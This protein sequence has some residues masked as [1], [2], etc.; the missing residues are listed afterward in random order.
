MNI[1]KKLIAAISAAVSVSAFAATSAAVYANETTTPTDVT[2]T[3]SDEIST[4]TTTTE[5]TTNTTDTSE[6]SDTTTTTTAPIKYTAWLSFN[7]GGKTQAE[8]AVEFSTNGTYTVKYKFTA[9]DANTVIDSIVLESD[10]TTDT[11]ADFKFK[12]TSIKVGTDENTA[13]PFS[14]DSATNDAF[15]TDQTSKTYLLNIINTDPDIEDLSVSNEFKAVADETLFVTFTVEGLA[16]PETTTTTTTTR[17]I[18]YSGYSNNGYNTNNTTTNTVSKT[19]DEGVIA[20]VV[21]A[22]AAAALAAGAV[23]MKKK[24]K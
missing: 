2:T 20:I 22:V 6:T 5:T 24:R 9:E 12:I 10:V 17:T 14:F 3:S 8:N 23:T 19:A 16:A 7:K 4:D 11:A 18:T 15:S 1:V 13:S 21:S